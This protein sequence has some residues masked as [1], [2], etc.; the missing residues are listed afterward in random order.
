MLREQYDGA[1][2][3]PRQRHGFTGLGLP[4]EAGAAMLLLKLPPPRPP[5]RAKVAPYEAG[6]FGDLEGRN[7]ARKKKSCA[8]ST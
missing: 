1:R 8:E 5:V 2:P 6:F 7:R 4:T 3:L